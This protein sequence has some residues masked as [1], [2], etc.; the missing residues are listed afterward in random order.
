MMMY[1]PL[2]AVVIVD[3][4]FIKQPLGDALAAGVNKDV[5]ILA[6]NVGEE[7]D[8]SPNIDFS[9]NTST[10]AVLQFVNQ[11]LA[12]WGKAMG[13]PTFGA[14]LLQKHFA[15]ALKENRPQQA[16]LQISG[17]IGTACG[18]LHLLQQAEAGGSPTRPLHY[19]VLKDGPSHPQVLGVADK[20]GYVSK[21]AYHQ[22]DLLWAMES[23]DWFPNFTGEPTNYAPTPDDVAQ[24]ALLRSIYIGFASSTGAS[25]PCGLPPFRSGSRE[26]RNTT[27]VSSSGGSYTVGSIGKTA[28]TA[29]P[30]WQAVFCSAV[31]SA[32][33]WEGFW[34]KN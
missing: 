18:Q 27:A 23:W 28:V 10:E 13:E 22:V 17:Q 25:P 4:D 20:A 31:K 6:S 2:P 30:G 19:G 9:S 14:D 1:R 7:D 3:G 32:G 29:V 15:D 12:P 26:R 16:Y 11:Q 5:G 34:W 8:L 33:L 24:A 21:Y